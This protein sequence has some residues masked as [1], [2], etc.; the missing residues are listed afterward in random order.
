MVQ[1]LAGEKSF[2]SSAKFPEQFLGCTQPPAQWV[3]GAL[4]PTIEWPGREANH[5]LPSSAKVMNE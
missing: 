3:K 2:I 5:T 1:F 4:A